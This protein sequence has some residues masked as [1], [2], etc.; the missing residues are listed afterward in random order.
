L[1]VLVG[2]VVVT[3]WRLLP[4]KAAGAA[5]YITPQAALVAGIVL[6]LAGLT[7]FEGESKKL[8][9]VLIQVCVVLLG[10]RLDLR[11]LWSELAHGGLLAVATVVG[12][13]GV[14]LLLG[15]LLATGR[16]VSLLVS[17][18][19]AICGGS[20]IAAVGSSIGASSSGMAVSTA[21]IFVLNAVGLFV[22][23]VV[24][25]RLGLSHE[26]FGAWA[27]V[28]LHDLASVGAAGNAYAHDEGAGAVEAVTNAAMIVK[29]TR[30]I[31][32]TPIALAAR[33]WFSRTGEGG[34]AK[35]PFPWFVVGFLAASAVRTFVPAVAG[36]AAPVGMAAGYGFQLALFLIGAGLSVKALK[37]VG[38]RALVQ[39]A[40]LWV[41][42]SAVSLWA[43]RALQ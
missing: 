35:A 43:V 9:R 7:A 30:V 24:G 13:I 36:Y 29:L 39:A 31:W 25:H 17:S 8:S 2:L 41:I 34:A 14:G 3:P 40:V 37:T 10:L 1:F 27:G 33:A 11:D 19:T 22:L 4:G 16:E 23:P 42:V 15:R 32:I 5:E 18:G 38:W 26:E 21:V 12:T 20:A 28:S 6:A